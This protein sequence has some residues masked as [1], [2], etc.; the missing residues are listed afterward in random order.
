MR[1][2]LNSAL[3]TA[4]SIDGEVGCALLDAQLPCC[5]CVAVCLC[6]TMSVRTALA[7]S[8]KDTS[9]CCAAPDL[10]LL[11][12]HHTSHPTAPH[13]PSSPDHITTPTSPST[14]TSTLPLPALSRSRPKLFLFHP[15]GLWNVEASW[16]SDPSRTPPSLIRPLATPPP[17]TLLALGTTSTTTQP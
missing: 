8:I 11:F 5:C 14:S 3:P 1:V 12:I 10:R 16:S 7:T 4:A 9:C 6:F 17:S 15:L 13:P 2:L